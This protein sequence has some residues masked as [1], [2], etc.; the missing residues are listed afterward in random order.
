MHGEIAFAEIAKMADPQPN[1]S[2]PSSPKILSYFSVIVSGLVLLGFFGML[3][4]LL[5]RDPAAFQN[6]G[7]IQNVLFTLL[8]AL[9]AAFS[10]VVNYWLGSS[11]E[12]ADKTQLLIDKRDSTK[13]S[14]G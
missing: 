14:S 12:S 5:T 7:S 10:Q 3:F 8:G 11:K 9:A 13:S 2:I 1:P 4:V 6:M